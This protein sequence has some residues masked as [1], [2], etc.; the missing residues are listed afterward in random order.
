MSSQ[1]HGQV[2]ET[3]DV[4]HWTPRFLLLKKKSYFIFLTSIQA[5]V[6]LDFCKETEETINSGYLPGKVWD[7]RETAFLLQTLSVGWI[8]IFKPCVPIT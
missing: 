7:G 3:P 2:G 5:C 4:K 8:Y 1:T 6:C